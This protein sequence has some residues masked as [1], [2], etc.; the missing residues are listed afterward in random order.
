MQEKYFVRTNSAQGPVDLS[1]SNLQGIENLYVL[2]GNSTFLRNYIIKGVAKYLEKEE[3]KFEEIISPFNISQDDAVIIRDNKTAIID[4]KIYSQKKHCKVVDTDKFLKTK[5]LV[6]YKDRMEELDKKSKSSLAS[7]YS[8]YGE[9]KKIHDDWEKIY[10]SNMDFER[11]NKFCDGLI[12]SMIPKRNNGIGTENLERFFGSSTPFGSVNYI[13]S[14][15]DGLKNRYFIKGRPGTGKSTFLKKL[16]R[17]TIEN[18]YKTQTYYCSFD[19]KSL[20]MVVVPELSL[21]VFDSTAPHEIFPKREGDTILDFYKESGLLGTD[22][23]YEKELKEIK[24]MYA[25][26]IAEGVAKL[27]LSCGYEKEK[28]YYF[29]KCSEL[30]LADK[31]IDKIVRKIL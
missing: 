2:K 15:T 30:E 10:N 3:K 6:E 18:G 19:T 13:E 24:K 31:T 25:F 4:E 7:L 28:E 29:E 23:K 12:D 22:E 1:E 27:N 9:A 11:L 8:A 16:L 20:D 26:R 17:S 5:K 21:C 14:L